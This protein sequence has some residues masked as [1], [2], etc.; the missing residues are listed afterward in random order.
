MLKK[1]SI[2]LLTIFM[3]VPAMAQPEESCECMFAPRAGQWEF[4]LVMGQNQFFGNEARLS[5]TLLPNSYGEA[6]GSTI[7]K[8]VEDD[9]AYVTTDLTRTINIGFLNTNNLA[10]MIGVQARYFI[11]NRI[12]LNFMG[13][14]NVNIQPGKD[15]VE[16]TIFGMAHSNT[17]NVGFHPE[18]GTYDVG[19]IFAHKAILA[20]VQNAAIGQLGSNYYF[21]VPNERINPYIGVYGQVKWA[22]I[23]AY[24][25]AYT[26]QT[27][28]VDEISDEN[29][30][31]GSGDQYGDN[32]PIELYREF[33]R[34]GQMLGFGGGIAFGVQYSL[35]EGLILGLEFSPV[36]YQYTLLHLQINGQTPY[37][38]SNH[39]VSVFKYPQLKLG[40]RF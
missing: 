23:N 15:Y 8:S 3:V 13:A 20:S 16:G 30:K 37:Y 21:T 25:P 14:Y 17:S 32:L 34:A 11:T 26:G 7:G 39:N 28:T 33:G 19:D 6:I 1:L 10:N 35:M 31:D 4:D 29:A 22:R 5:T 27:V 40:F 9:A 38:A 36:L 2:L 12:D 24:Y 18:T